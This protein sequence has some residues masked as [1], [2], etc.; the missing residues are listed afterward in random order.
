VPAH[1]PRGVYD[2]PGA[3]WAEAD[4]DEAVVQ[5]RRLADDPTL[6]AAIGVRARA[7]AMA[8]LTTA[9]LAEALRGLGLPVS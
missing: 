9:P 8:R 1:D 6:R 5:L 3:E 7:A 4:L 2:V